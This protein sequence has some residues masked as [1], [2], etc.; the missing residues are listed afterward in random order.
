MSTV[1]YQV[2]S[3]QSYLPR[4][5]SEKVYYLLEVQKVK[6]WSTEAA[7]Y[8]HFPRYFVM[9]ENLVHC[10]IVCCKGTVLWQVYLCFLLTHLTGYT[11][12]IEMLINVRIIVHLVFKLKEK[13][14]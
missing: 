8:N 9:I 4:E 11:E 3:N 13:L 2:L 14:C 1:V 5:K 7:V 12:K 6:V 10:K